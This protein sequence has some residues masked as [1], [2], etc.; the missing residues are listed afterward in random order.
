MENTKMCKKCK[1]ALN[2]NAYSCVEN[3][4]FIDGLPIN[5]G[6]IYICDDC[7]REMQEQEL[8][9]LIDS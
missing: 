1:A 9:Q 6:T 7:G 5:C 8:K 3:L 2:T 4:K